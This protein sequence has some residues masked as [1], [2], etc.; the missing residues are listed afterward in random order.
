MNFESRQHDCVV[1][2]PL[3]TFMEYNDTARELF[4]GP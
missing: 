3:G 2:T 1:A 4:R